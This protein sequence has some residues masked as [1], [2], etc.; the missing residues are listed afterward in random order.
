VSKLE[1]LPLNTQIMQKAAELWAEARIS[2]FPTAPPD[3]LDGDV[4]LAAQAIEVSGIVITY[5]RKHL[6]RFVETKG[7]EEIVIR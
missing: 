6:S 3:A 7:W 1:Y 4:I 2:G 5:N